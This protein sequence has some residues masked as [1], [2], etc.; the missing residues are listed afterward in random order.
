MKIRPSSLPALRECPRFVPDQSTGQ[1][2]K[3]A[4]T[5][6]HD[7]LFAVLGGDASKLDDLTEPDRSGV[8]WAS[9]YIRTHA[10]LSDYPLVREERC[11]FLD[12][13]FERIEGTPDAFCGPELFDLKWREDVSDYSPQIAAYALMLESPKVRAHILHGLTR[14]AEVIEFTQES[15]EALV[16]PIIARAKDPESKPSACSYCGWCANR[17]T[18]TAVLQKVA[19]SQAAPDPATITDASAMGDALRTARIVSDWCEAVEKR[20][21]AMAFQEGVVPAGFRP[22][23]QR[24]RRQIPDISAAFSMC[25]LPQTE[26]LSACKVGFSDL[27]TSYAKFNGIAAAAAERELERKLGDSLSRAPDVRMLKTKPKE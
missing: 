7:V 5:K 27:V 26:F 8:E 22:V 14:R 18:C 20:A 25:G 13:D 10:P 1:D 12:G 15:A 17:L 21:K 4:G 3:S 16:F 11:W 6:R 23:I 2:D 24:G 9:A 19:E